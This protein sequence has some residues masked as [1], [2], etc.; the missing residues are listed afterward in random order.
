MIGE[1]LRPAALKTRTAFFL[2]TLGM[3]A[4]HQPLILRVPDPFNGILFRPAML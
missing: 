1:S 3:L 2:E 4:Q